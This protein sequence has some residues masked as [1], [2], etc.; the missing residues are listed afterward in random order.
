M[1]FSKEGARI[2]GK[3]LLHETAR[4]DGGHRSSPLPSYGG[5]W[6]WPPGSSG[7]AHPVPIP[8]QSKRDLL[9]Q[10]MRRDKAALFPQPTLELSQE[11]INTSRCA[12]QGILLLGC[13]C[14]AYCQLR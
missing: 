11:H 1:P 4:A 10:E 14:I 2:Q 8:F 12:M 13:E 6:I 9:E 3:G 5:G 7:L